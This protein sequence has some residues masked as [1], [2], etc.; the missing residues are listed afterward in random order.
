[1]K[2]NVDKRDAIRQIVEGYPDLRQITNIEFDDGHQAYKNDKGDN[3]TLRGTLQPKDLTL[4]QLT[5]HS[6]PSA[7]MASPGQ[8]SNGVIHVAEAGSAA[9]RK[10]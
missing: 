10:G 2:G 5:P 6:L 9:L 7:P 1:M 4:N 3:K 8:A